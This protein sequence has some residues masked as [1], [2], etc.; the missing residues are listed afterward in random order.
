M[1]FIHSG[2]TLTVAVLFRKLRGKCFFTKG[3]ICI[4][5]DAARYKSTAIEIPNDCHPCVM[6]L[7]NDPLWHW[8]TLLSFCIV[9]FTC[10]GK[11]KHWLSTF[12]NICVEYMSVFLFFFPLL[13]HLPELC[14]LHCHK[15][16]KYKW[17]LYGAFLF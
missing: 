8:L 5:M 11:K 13:F 6:M 10:N 9:C 1:R 7:S 15:V 16:M 14:K 3:Y 2:I 4:C 17:K 12:E